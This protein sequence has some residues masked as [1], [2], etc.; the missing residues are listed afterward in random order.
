LAWEGRDRESIVGNLSKGFLVLRGI[1][2]A[3]KWKET[4]KRMEENK[5]K[6]FA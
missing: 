5:K 4:R 2:Q 3:E 1:G 6:C